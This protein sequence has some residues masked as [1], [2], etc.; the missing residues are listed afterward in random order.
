ML[1]LE[2]DDRFE[3]FLNRLLQLLEAQWKFPK[4]Y[5]L[6]KCWNVIRNVNSSKSQW[7]SP[8]IKW[9]I[10]WL[11]DSNWLCFVEYFLCRNSE[12][13]TLE[14]NKDLSTARNQPYCNYVHAGGDLTSQAFWKT[15]S[16]QV[17]Y[18]NFISPKEQEEHCLKT[19]YVFGKTCSR[20]LRDSYPRQFSP[21]T[22][23]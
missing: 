7:Y 20:Y 8:L 1:T 14:L 18:S 23:L 11:N 19:L 6:F 13:M 2:H 16:W 10:L 3:T 4:K 5:E 9:V 15:T 17:T 22:H 12:R 21:C